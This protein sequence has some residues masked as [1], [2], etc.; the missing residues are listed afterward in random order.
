MS[1][2]KKRAKAIAQG[3]DLKDRIRL[4]AW[5][6]LD[7]TPRTILRAIP[8]LKPLLQV[9]KDQLVGGVTIIVG[10][11]RFHLVDSES[12]FILQPEFEEWMWKYLKVPRG[13]V[14]VDVGAH[15][16]KYAIP[17]AKLVG[18]GGLVIAVEPHPD[19]YKQLVENVKLNRVK[20]VVAL[21]I[22][23][24]SEES[25][26]KLFIGD[27]HGHHSLVYDF[28]RGFVLVRAKPLDDVLK[29]LGVGRVDCIKVDVEGAEFEV[30]KGMRRTLEKF[31]P[32]VVAEVRDENLERIESF[33][34]QVRYA[35]ECV[36][37]M[38]YVLKP[39]PT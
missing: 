34:H 3:E 6:M 29:E 28:G 32:I 30:L 36:A 16:G 27:A 22:A 17:M 21:N 23:A 1:Y 33:L 25:E 15:V 12:I 35:M 8:L 11:Y 19:N 37:P 9:L 20:N 39:T 5:T 18:P 38:Y 10:K 24:W 31:K 14:F 7:S 26:M 4:F 2:L 13:G